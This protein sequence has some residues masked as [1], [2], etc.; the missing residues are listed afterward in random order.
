MVSLLLHLSS[1]TKH[2]LGKKGTVLNNFTA[3]THLVGV[4][5]FF[6]VLINDFGRVLDELFPACSN[7]SSEVTQNYSIVES[8]KLKAEL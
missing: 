4:L 6:M 2:I 7:K 3:E 8:M 5:D 1:R